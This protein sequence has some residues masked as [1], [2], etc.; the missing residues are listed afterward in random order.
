ML[1]FNATFFAQLFHFVVLLVLLRIFV[2]KPVLNIIEER[3]K[4]VA[5]NIASAEQQRAEA[6][7]LKAEY[8]AEMQK[9][10]EEARN[11]IDRATKAAEEQAQEIIEQ[12]KAEA[13][14]QKEAA[15]SDIQREKDKAIAELRDQVASLA[16]LVARKVTRDGLTVEAHDRLVQDAVKEVGQLQ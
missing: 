5:D 12:A 16:V 10:R 8:E 14:R 3:R 7:K 11:I 15:L 2:Y 1:E 13:L 9:A 6:E 4:L